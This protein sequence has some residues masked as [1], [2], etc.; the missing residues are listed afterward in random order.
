M[1]CGCNCKLAVL[2]CDG[3]DLPPTIFW[4]L[5]GFPV[6]FCDLLAAAVF[7]LCPKPT[8]DKP[9]LEEEEININEEAVDEE[10]CKV[11][12]ALV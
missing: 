11:M 10:E 8:A 3:F 6:F 1:S 7:C 12:L 9:T 5:E 4:N 2:L